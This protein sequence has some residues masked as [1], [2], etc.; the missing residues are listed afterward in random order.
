MRCQIHVMLV[1]Q[2]GVIEVVQTRKHSSRMHT[3]HS[4]TVHARVATRCQHW[5]WGGKVVV[6]ALRRGVQG[7]GCEF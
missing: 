6:A 7:R 3:T 1:R 4:P 5:G 2:H